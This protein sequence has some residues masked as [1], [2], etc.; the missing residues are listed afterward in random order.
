MDKFLQ[1]VPLNRVVAGYRRTVRGIRADRIRCVLVARDTD[2]HISKEIKRLCEERNIPYRITGTKREM[3]EKLGL[4]VGCAV[5]GEAI[6]STE[7]I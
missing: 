1:E 4:D 3:G 5:C 2:E 7:G 6:G